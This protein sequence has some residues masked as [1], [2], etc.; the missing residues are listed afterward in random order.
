MKITNFETFLLR[1]PVSSGAEH[2][3]GPTEW[4]TFDYVLLRIDTEGG[5]SGWG[6]GFGYWVPEATR[7][8]LDHTIGP[9]LIGRDAREI[10]AITQSLQR[11]FHLSGRYGITM[12]AI[13]AVDIALWDIAGKSAGLPLHRMLGGGRRSEIPA[14]ASLFRY[15]RPE[16]V[17][18]QTRKALD[19]GYRQVKLH[20]VTEEAVAA[21]REAA[22]PDVALM[23]DTNC[24][25]TPAQARDMTER[26]LDYDLHWLEEPIFPP[27]DFQALSH[28]QATTGMPLAAGE[29]CCTAFQ[30][31]AMLDAGAVTYAQPSVTKVGGISEMSKV[32]TLAETHGT[33]VVPHCPYFGPGLLASLHLLATM[34]EDVLAEFL[35]YDTLEASPYGDAVVPVGGILQV[36]QGPGLGLEPDPAVLRDYAG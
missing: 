10:G 23:V 4:P 12:F 1:L 13:S 22:G 27:E 19:E 35:Y 15:G 29:N 8:V 14:Y 34:A 7:A 3:S 28:L 16:R 11:E 20:E 31:K 33:A 32:I 21:A 36:P 9:R 17:A 18:E 26:L 6:D 2:A 25:W 24:P 5:P 30:F